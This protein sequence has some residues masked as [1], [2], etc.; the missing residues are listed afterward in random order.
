MY[1][2]CLEDQGRSQGLRNDFPIESGVRHVRWLPHWQSADSELHASPVAGTRSLDARSRMLSMKNEGL[3]FVRAGW[4]CWL[5]LVAFGDVEHQQLL[6]SVKDA[7][8]V[9]MR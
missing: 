3:I 8:E 9:S 2:D 4:G 7:R 5:Q 1:L 6:W